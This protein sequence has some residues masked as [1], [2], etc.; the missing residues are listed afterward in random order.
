MQLGEEFG[1]SHTSSYLTL[2]NKA[3]SKGLDFAFDRHWNA[4]LEQVKKSANKSDAKERL[5]FEVLSS[6]GQPFQTLD[7]NSF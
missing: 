6:E 7:V 4:A 5:A 1:V 3:L 2:Q